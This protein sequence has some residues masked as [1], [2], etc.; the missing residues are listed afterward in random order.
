M[1]VKSNVRGIKCAHCHGRHDTVPE[2]RDCFVETQ[3]NEQEAKSEQAA[4]MAAE[5]WFEERGGAVD[6]PIERQKWA[7][8]DQMMS[9]AEET[10]LIQ[11]REREDDERAYAS[12]AARDKEEANAF[13]RERGRRYREG[14]DPLDEEAEA[15]ARL[16]ALAG[17]RGRDMASEKQVK[18]VMDL[19]QQRIW[20]DD[21]SKADVENMERRQVTKL[22]NG[23]KTAPKRTLDSP[24]PDVP[25]G[26]YAL[27]RPGA[28]DTPGAYSYVDRQDLVSPNY[29][30]W[31]FY[32]VDRPTE[33]QYK[34]RTYLNLLVGAPGSYRR[35]PQH[36]MPMARVL[37]EI[38]ADPKKAMVDYGLQSGVCGRCNSPLTDEGSLARGLGPVCAK[39]SGW[40]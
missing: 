4:E 11:Q 25:A 22:I 36:G 16:D 13:Y 18:Y 28:D 29:G 33:G 34:G 14:I 7:N 26:R 35:I 21:F 39:K 32:Q 17:S 2:V 3:R 40:F 31:M 1:T 23:L 5:R 10:R 9:D 38:L 20:P 8:E 19:L 15:S 30:K 6:D 37:A 12:K 24:I 27:Y